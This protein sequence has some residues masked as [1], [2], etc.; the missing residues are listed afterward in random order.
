MDAVTI[1]GWSSYSLLVDPLRDTTFFIR[2]TTAIN[3]RIKLNPPRCLAYVLQVTS[4]FLMTDE[5][6]II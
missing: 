5:N 6:D 4:D 2:Q 1:R 3:S